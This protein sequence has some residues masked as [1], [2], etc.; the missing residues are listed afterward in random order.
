MLKIKTRKTPPQN[1]AICSKGGKVSFAVLLWFFPLSKQLCSDTLGQM[2]EP[3]EGPHRPSSPEMK[4]HR[5]RGLFQ[6]GGPKI[7][8]R[9]SEHLTEAGRQALTY[10][11][12]NRICSKNV[13]QGLLPRGKNL[14]GT[15][16]SFFT[17]KIRNFKK[18][19]DTQFD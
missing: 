12:I 5:P 7:S 16:F 8:S 6:E 4:Q 15:Q 2:R 3:W 19:T 14:N 9:C 10:R 13:E 11:I 1:K 17:F 18:K